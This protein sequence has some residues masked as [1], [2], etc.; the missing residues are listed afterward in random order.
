MVARSGRRCAAVDP[1]G[2]DVASSHN[3]TPMRQAIRASSPHVLAHAVSY[4]EA[5]FPAHGRNADNFIVPD[6]RPAFS[7]D[8]TG[9][10]DGAISWGESLTKEVR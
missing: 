2:F 4:R 5:C 9:R 3:I 7:P 1:G 10:T 8:T 6:V